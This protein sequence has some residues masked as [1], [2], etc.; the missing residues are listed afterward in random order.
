MR[1]WSVVH[2]DEKS[3][4]WW[5]GA[6]SFTESSFF[7]IPPDVMLVA[8]LTASR[9]W[10]YYAL[11]TTLGSVAGGVAGYFIG[12]FFFDLV[13]VKIIAFYHLQDEMQKVGELYADNA[14][15]SIFVAAFT[16]IPYKVFT[17]SAGFFKINFLTFIFASIIGRG[18]RFFI[19]GYLMK[20]F[21]HLMGE[22]IYKYFNI[23]SL[24]VAVAIVGGIL[25]LYLL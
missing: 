22:T 13:G 11:V 21:G 16:P 23:F 19:V 5:L 1:Q 12:H 14:F 17:I 2:A 25:L 6:L 20:M 3:T 18:L 24:L 8:I 10:A 7:P 15:W 4:S 9:R